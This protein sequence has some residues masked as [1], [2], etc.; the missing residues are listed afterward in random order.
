[1]YDQVVAAVP[2]AT[3]AMASLELRKIFDFLNPAGYLYLLEPGSHATKLPDYRR[4]EYI[5]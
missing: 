2:G 3:H 5:N 1:M 4:S